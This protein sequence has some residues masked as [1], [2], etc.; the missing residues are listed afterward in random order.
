MDI[1]DDLVYWDELDS[2]IM[3]AIRDFDTWQ[4]IRDFLSDIPD[5]GEYYSI[6]GYDGIVC[7]DDTFDDYKSDVIRAMD[8]CNAWGEEEDSSD[9]E[10]DVVE[11]ETQ[12][13]TTEEEEE[14]SIDDASFLAV[15]GGSA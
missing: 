12:I 9:D 13:H 7:V 4:G 5:G 2:Y 11:S 10:D 15:V 6:D 1:C 3:C 14:V 8:Q